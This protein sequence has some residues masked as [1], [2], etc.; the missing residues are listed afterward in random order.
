VSAG[1][2]T[3]LPVLLRPKAVL[4]AR[5]MLKDDGRAALKSKV[6]SAGGSGAP[7]AS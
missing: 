2:A 5:E 1:K 4:L 6:L 3:H 7:V